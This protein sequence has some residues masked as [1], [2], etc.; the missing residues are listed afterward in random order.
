MTSTLQD[1]AFE[2]TRASDA[3]QITFPQVVG[4]LIAAGVERYH[5]DLVRAE[6]TYYK[7]DGE[8]VV[9]PGHALASAPAADF[10]AS[11]VEAAVRAIQAG[12]I[13]YREFCARIADAGCVGYF[14]T[15]TGRRAVYHGRTGE[16]YVEPFPPAR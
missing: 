16:S 1:V 3:E 7:P 9:T 11:L 12:K 14:V 4:K 13:Q 6:R 8:S 15:L 5:A 2:C 10:S